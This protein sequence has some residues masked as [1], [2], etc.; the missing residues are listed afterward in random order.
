MK[1]LCLVQALHPTH[2]A[3]AVRVRGGQGAL[4]DGPIAETQATLRCPA[5]LDS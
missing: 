4:Y 2:A 3:T 5:L 1:Y